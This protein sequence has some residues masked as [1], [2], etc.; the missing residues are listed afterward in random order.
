MT[1]NIPTMRP[2]LPIA[3]R[4][5]EYLWRID[6]SRLY[7][8][9]GPLA[10]ALEDRLAEHYGLDK[11]TV[12]TVANA[13]LGLSLALTAQGAKPGTLC[14]LPAWT[15]VASAHAVVNAGLIPYFI[16]VDPESWAL[17]AAA[18]MDQ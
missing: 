4:L 1:P 2:K 17:S 16:D 14:A 18:V 3:E 15:F 5:V 11:G 9:F 12:T 8:N 13:T 6:Q 10:C 7:T